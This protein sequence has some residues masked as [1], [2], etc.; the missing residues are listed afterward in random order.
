M[1]GGEQGWTGMDRDFSLS[2]V[3]TIL[4]Y[5]PA[6]ATGTTLVAMMVQCELRLSHFFNCLNMAHL[7]FYEVFSIFT[8]IYKHIG[9]PWMLTLIISLSKTS[10]WKYMYLYHSDIRQMLV[11][12]QKQNNESSEIND[13]RKPI[14]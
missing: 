8:Q 6:L 11:F 4:V 13:P 5:S 1:L 14:L 2:I 10:S 12:R 9:E 3:H 7:S